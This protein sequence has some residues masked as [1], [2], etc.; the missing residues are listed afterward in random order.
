MAT[1]RLMENSIRFLGKQSDLEK[2][3][4]SHLELLKVK[5]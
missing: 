2:P 5:T 3:K 1:K 4:Q